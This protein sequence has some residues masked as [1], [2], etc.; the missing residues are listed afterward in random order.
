MYTASTSKPWLSEAPCWGL[1]MD[2][3]T[4]TLTS[5]WKVG[6]GVSLGRQVTQAQWG[7]PVGDHITRVPAGRNLARW[8]HC[9]TPLAAAERGPLS[10]S[11]QTV[12]TG[13]AALRKPPRSL[14]GSIPVVATRPTDTEKWGGLFIPRA[15]WTVWLYVKIPVRILNNSSFHSG[16]C[17]FP[18]ILS[19]QD[20]EGHKDDL[21]QDAL[22][23]L[24]H[25]S[26]W[27]FLPSPLTELSVT[28]KHNSNISHDIC[29]SALWDRGSQWHYDFQCPQLTGKETE[30]LNDRKHTSTLGKNMSLFAILCHSCIVSHLVNLFNNLLLME[31]LLIFGIA[32]CKNLLCTYFLA[33]MCMCI[34]KINY[35][36]C[37]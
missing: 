18:H 2:Q 21:K 9:F 19:S 25:Q 10:E 17:C 24:T 30:A 37:I 27:W 7:S 32:Y 26:N 15:G 5:P 33:Y 3:L 28:Y 8:A 31:L 16:G 4:V 20:S 35:L 6:L 13:G 29:T 22:A 23:G 36:K 14:Y 11:W 12:P 1:H 34:S